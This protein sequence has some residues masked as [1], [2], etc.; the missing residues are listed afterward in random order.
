MQT[1][2]TPVAVEAA[3]NL[4]IP[5]DR[6][7]VYLTTT[8]NENI[9]LNEHSLPKPDEAALPIITPIVKLNNSDE[10]PMESTNSIDE[11]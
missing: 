10:T 1:P 2:T 7:T 9:Q 5:N 3:N 11:R 6:S 4:N 8:I